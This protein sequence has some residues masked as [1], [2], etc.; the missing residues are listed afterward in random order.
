M[1]APER[2]RGARGLPARLA[3]ASV[4]HHGGLKPAFRASGRRR[5][6]GSRLAPG[7]TP[8]PRRSRGRAPTRG[9]GRWPAAAASP[10]LQ[11]ADLRDLQP[12]AQLL[13]ELLR[14]IGAHRD[15]QARHFRRLAVLFVV[16]VV[17]GHV[18]GALAVRAPVH[19]GARVA[20]AAAL[21]PDLVGQRL[22]A[23]QRGLVL[24]A[25]GVALGV[26]QLLLEPVMEAV[27]QLEVV[28]GVRMAGIEPEAVAEIADRR[29]RQGQRVLVFLRGGERLAIL[30]HADVVLGAAGQRRIVG[31]E[32]G[33]IAIERLLL[34]A[35]LEQRVAAVELDH[36]R[37][38]QLLR[39]RLVL[40]Q[41]RLVLA[42][43]VER[44]ALAHGDL[45]LVRAEDRQQR[46]QAGPQPRPCFPRFASIHAVSPRALRMIISSTNRTTASRTK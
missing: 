16:G 32:R 19:V 5:Q 30:D 37:I 20:L 25:R 12:L 8:A 21:V 6:S 42:R 2:T 28:A 24:R 40:A 9:S 38:G 11:A 1:Q 22:A 34:V 15:R 7:R 13:H 23:P 3:P 17:L 31:R 46:E 4:E 29:L 26:Q 18:V 43:A 27:R 44:I 35:V 41:R 10:L 45:G 33:E 39:R 36:G 14:S